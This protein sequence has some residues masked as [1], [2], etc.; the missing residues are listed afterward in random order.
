MLV[1][2]KRIRPMLRK[3][4]TVAL[5]AGLAI[6][7]TAPAALAETFDELVAKAG[8]A[9]RAG[10]MAKTAELLRK[11]IAIKPVPALLNNLGRVQEDMGD[12]AG[13]VESYSKV[14]NDPN[15]DANLRSLDAARIATLQAKLQKGWVLARVAPSGSSVLVDGRPPA[16]PPGKEFPVPPGQAVLQFTS[17][18][19]KVAAVVKN[20]YPLGKRTTMTVSLKTPPNNAW[21]AVALSSLEPKP[22]SIT[23]DGYAVRKAGGLDE[24][25]MS[26]GK[27][28]L[29]M[30]YADGRAISLN[31]SLAAGT[32]ESIA[33]SVASALAAVKKV[34]QP[35]PPKV[36]PA[37]MSPW[38]YVLMG[39]GAVAVGVGVFLTVD[40]DDDRDEVLNPIKDSRGVI[41]SI[42]LDKAQE[43]E[44]DADAKASGG[45]AAIGVG[46]ALLVGG[47]VWAIVDSM[48]GDTETKGDV[49]V[50]LGFG[51][52]GLSGSF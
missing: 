6:T 39:L 7:L 37:G 46:G 34:T 35:P 51:S 23:V 32:R 20:A 36:E 24:L 5:L 12:Y 3:S 52:I 8:Q 42:T 27:H 19:G 1:A 9:R 10:D 38:P 43:V 15:A 16:A 47:I 17:A 45:V 26:P 50:S 14:A 30:A 4:R 2:M 41:T 25:R 18:D 31:V 21:G 29:K 48:G 33:S 28:T 49:D 11:A 13:A 22:K 40:A 44:A